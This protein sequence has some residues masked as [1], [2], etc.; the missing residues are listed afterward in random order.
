[1]QHLIASFEYQD[2]STYRS[3][4]SQPHLWGKLQRGEICDARLAQTIWIEC[5]EGVDY[6]LSF[7]DHAPVGKT[8]NEDQEKK[9]S[10]V[11][12]RAG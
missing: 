2:K 4:G 3:I 8:Y 6:N 9:T 7:M 11:L 10:H 5:S 1:M 12:L